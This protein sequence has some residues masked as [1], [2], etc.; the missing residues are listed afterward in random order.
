[1]SKDRKYAIQAKVNENAKA[2]TVEQQ[3]AYTEASI[4][5]ETALN[6]DI[7][8][9]L[10]DYRYEASSFI[11]GDVPNN[12]GKTNSVVEMTAVRIKT[13]L[14]E[15]MSNISDIGNAGVKV[16]MC[17]SIKQGLRVLQKS[18]INHD[19]LLKRVL[20]GKEQ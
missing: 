17:D 2:F 1:M 7:D 9:V 12:P 8:R 3:K 14:Q 4:A 5:I 16:M 11:L 18:S 6:E 13:L 15:I 19:I 20:G 10:E